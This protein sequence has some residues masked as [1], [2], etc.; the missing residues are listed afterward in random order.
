VEERFFAFC[1]R[2]GLPQ[3]KV[4]QEIA[5]ATEILQVDFLW[6]DQRLIVET[7]SRDW[8]STIRTRERDAH[9]D[10][11]LDDAGYRVRRCTWAQIVY[12]P[13]RLAAVLRDLLAH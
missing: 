7:D 12:E 11:L 13:E 3:P 9:R 4:H 6:R 10:R 5:T 2:Q 8:H 1:R